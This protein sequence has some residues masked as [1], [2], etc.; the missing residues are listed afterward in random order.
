MTMLSDG[1]AWLG[2]RLK[3]S[4]GIELVYAETYSLT[5]TP[6]QHEYQ[7]F[8]QSAGLVTSVLHYD[9]T[10]TASDLSVTPR[11]GDRIT[12]ALG[13]F[14]VLPIGNRPCFERLDSSGVLLL[15]HSKKVA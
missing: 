11:K 15:I 6:S 3:E 12:C 9:W 14:E 13:T 8:D 5:A 10:I 1:A 7:I 2:E 4:A